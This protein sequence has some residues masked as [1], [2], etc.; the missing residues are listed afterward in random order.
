MPRCKKC[1]TPYQ[2]IGKDD[3]L[4]T[5]CTFDELFEHPEEVKI[6]A[7]GNKMGRSQVG[8]SRRR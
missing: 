6:Y 3:G 2:V 1:G 8:G 4:C 5:M 7:L